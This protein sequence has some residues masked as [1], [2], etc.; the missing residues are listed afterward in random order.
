MGRNS[1]NFLNYC[2][3]FYPESVLPMKLLSQRP[4]LQDDLFPCFAAGRD[5]SSPMPWGLWFY[6][7]GDN[8]ILSQPPLCLVV[9]ARQLRHTRAAGCVASGHL[10][11]LPLSLHPPPPAAHKILVA[12]FASLIRKATV[13]QRDLA[14][15]PSS[16][17]CLEKR[18]SRPLIWF[19][20]CSALTASSARRGGGERGSMDPVW[21]CSKPGALWLGNIHFWFT[22]PSTELDL[23]CSPCFYLFF[24]WLVFIGLATY[25][26]LKKHK[27]K[28]PLSVL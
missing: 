8:P 22:A 24:S 15:A 27:N 4:C 6:V 26:G 20:L 10:Y 9:S 28:N 16:A 2:Y 7:L 23:L 13:L 11:T 25:A 5:G 17:L 14:W 12:P 21:C 3:Y 19:G 18:S 1:K